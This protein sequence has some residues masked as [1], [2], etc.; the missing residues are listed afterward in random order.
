MQVESV[1][2]KINQAE[3]IMSAGSSGGKE[4]RWGRGGGCLTNIF[5]KMCCVSIAY[6]VCLDIRFVMAYS[7]ILPLMHVQLTNFCLTKLP[8]PLQLEEGGWQHNCSLT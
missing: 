8:P 7:A 4:N 3:V 1:G 5:T 2:R 6:I